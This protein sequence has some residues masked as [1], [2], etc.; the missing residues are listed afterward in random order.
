MRALGTSPR[1][2]PLAS[3]T[4][5][6]R[7]TQLDAQKTNSIVAPRGNGRQ[8]LAGVP[9][10]GRHD[11]S[12]AKR[13]PL[14]SAGRDC[15]EGIMDGSNW[16]GGSAPVTQHSF[17]REA[18]RAGFVSIATAALIVAAAF[19]AEFSDISPPSTPSWDWPVVP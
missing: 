17:W 18:A 13:D 11:S 9:Q 10:F 3:L 14:N 6:M 5:L 7:L 15:E 1:S 16:P 19:A 8:L 4:R 12:K 2:R